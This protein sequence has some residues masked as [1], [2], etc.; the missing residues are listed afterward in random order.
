MLNFPKIFR[1]KQIKQFYLRSLT[2]QKIPSQDQLLHCS[3]E[4]PL[5]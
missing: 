4:I 1:Q 3:H 2:Y 5:S